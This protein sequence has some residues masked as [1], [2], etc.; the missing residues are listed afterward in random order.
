MGHA[1]GAGTDTRRHPGRGA[2]RAECAQFIQNHPVEKLGKGHRNPLPCP[3]R[4]RPGRVSSKGWGFLP[5]PGKGRR[6]GK[7]TSTAG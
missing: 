7:V 6:K 5:L 2:D 4:T 1:A 3:A